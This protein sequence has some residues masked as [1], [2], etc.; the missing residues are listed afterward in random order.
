MFKNILLPT[1]GS[2]LS[3]RAVVRG[4]ALAKS[5]GARVTGF[6]AAPPATPII[7]RDSLP[8]GYAAPEEHAKIIDKVTANV[9]EFV[10]RAA[11]K[12]GVRSE[13]VHV[14]SDFPEDDILKV[15]EKRKCDLIVMGTHGQSGL[16]GILS[17]VLPRKSLTNPR[18][19]SCLSDDR[20]RH[21]CA[22]TWGDGGAFMAM[23]VDQPIAGRLRGEYWYGI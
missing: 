1:D 17:G 14:T 5:V 13:A 10:M 18:Y 11:R 15:A 4:V 16:R 12:A 8:V 6:F 22:R 7:Y 23:T 2:P 19:P 3:R 9:L 20:R 21:R